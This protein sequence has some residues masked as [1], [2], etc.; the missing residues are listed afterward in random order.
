M[1]KDPD[2]QREA[3]RQASQRKRDRKGMT[4]GMTNEGMMPEGMTKQGM[5]VKSS[6]SNVIPRRGKDEGVTITTKGLHKLNLM[7]DVINEQVLG[8]KRGHDI[9][10]FE[11]LPP[12]VQQTID[13]ISESP[14]EKRKRTGIAIRYQQL[15]P[16]RYYSTGI[17]I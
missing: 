6:P 17:A 3:N 16:D 13:R 15:F 1:Y 2:K 9:K 14:E 11:D 8:K 5:T 12:D 7:A 4:Q 10:C